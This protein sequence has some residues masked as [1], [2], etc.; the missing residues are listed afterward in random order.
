MTDGAW[1]YLKAHVQGW[2]NTQRYPYAAKA[3]QDRTGGTKQLG[4]RISSECKSSIGHHMPL[5]S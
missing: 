5:G 2:R 4:L 3:S 1:M